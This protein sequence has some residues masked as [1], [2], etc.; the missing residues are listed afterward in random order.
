MHY[1][2][3]DYPVTVLP[4]GED[5]TGYRRL[6]GSRP[7]DYTSPAAGRCRPRLHNG[8]QG[9]RLRNR[10]P[11]NSGNSAIVSPYRLTSPIRNRARRWLRACK[12]LEPRLDILVNNAGTA[13]G[14]SYQ[15]FPEEAFDKVMDINVKA[16]FA[17]T[18]DLTPLLESA[19]TLQDPARV[20]NVGSIEGLHISSVHRTGNYAYT[21]SKAAV[22]HLTRHLAVHLGPRNITVNAVAP[23]FLPQQGDQLYLRQVQRRCSQQQSHQ[24]TG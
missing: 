18:R 7:D 6:P 12:P 21:A 14:A 15:E 10:Q 11:R 2:S 22:H 24:A 13:W 20:I 4:A 17:L 16:M 5:R 8:A 3:L 19:A 1:E 9:R 23:G